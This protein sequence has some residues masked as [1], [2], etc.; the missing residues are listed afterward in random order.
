MMMVQPTNGEEWHTPALEYGTT[1]VRCHAAGVVHE[2]PGVFDMHDEQEGRL[3]LIEGQL[4]ALTD[5][6]RTGSIMM[7]SSGHWT[8]TCPIGA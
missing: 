1:R 7:R 2:P 3:R 8:A 5:E 6:H 4:Q